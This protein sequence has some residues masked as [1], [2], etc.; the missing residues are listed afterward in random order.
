MGKVFGVLLAAGKSSRFSDGHKLYYKLD[1]R[2]MLLHSLESL[3]Q[4]PVSNIAVVLSPY[5]RSLL[6]EVRERATGEDENKTVYLY[7][8]HPDRGLVSTLQIA[9]QWGGGGRVN[10]WVLKE[11]SED[12]QERL[13]SEVRGQDTFDAA[14]VVPG[15]MPYLREQVFLRVLERYQSTGDI[16]IPRANETWTHPRIIPRRYFTAFLTES[17]LKKGRRILTRFTDQIQFVDVEEQETFV[18]IDSLDD[19]K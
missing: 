4:S 11:A 9:M 15:D 7:N 5:T 6:H 18:D 14:M 19:V 12:R 8:P 10:S 2:P 13:Y 1:G 16:V 3:F 17:S